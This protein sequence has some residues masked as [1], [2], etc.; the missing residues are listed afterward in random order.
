MD[1]AFEFAVNGPNMEFALYLM[2][3]RRTVPASLFIDILTEKCHLINKHL[4]KATDYLVIMASVTNTMSSIIF[5][6][7]NL[8]EDGQ[9]LHVTLSNLPDLEDQLIHLWMEVCGL[10]QYYHIDDHAAELASIDMFYSDLAYD[11]LVQVNFML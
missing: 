6:D 2:G 3:D 8:E 9:L 1:A 7:R 5:Y 4:R 10:L 11:K